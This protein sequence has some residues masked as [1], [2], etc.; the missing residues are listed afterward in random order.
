MTCPLRSRTSTHEG[1][2]KEKESA[3]LDT[4]GTVTEG[5]ADAADGTPETGTKGAGVAGTAGTAG[6]VETGIAG[7]AEPDPPGGVTDVLSDETP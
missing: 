5:A 6:V 7:A 4:T 3:A 2:V 1:R